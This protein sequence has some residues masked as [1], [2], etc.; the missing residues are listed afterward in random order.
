MLEM[1]AEPCR[2]GCGLSLEVCQKLFEH[3]VPSEGLTVGQAGL[4]MGKLKENDWKLP[5]AFEFVKNKGEWIERKFAGK[6]KK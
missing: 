5:A 2:C 3:G 6:Q 4:I 1:K